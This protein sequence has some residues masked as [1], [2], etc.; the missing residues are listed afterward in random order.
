MQNVLH[1]FRSVFLAGQVA[2]QQQLDSDSLHRTRH[3]PFLCLSF[4]CFFFKKKMVTISVPGIVAYDV[5]P[6]ILR[7][8]Q[9]ATEL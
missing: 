4:S 3:I 7:A 5:N 8:G 6:L 2:R 9:K 1:G